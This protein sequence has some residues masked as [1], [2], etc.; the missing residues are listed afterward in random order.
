MGVFYSPHYYQVHR[1][2]RPSPVRYGPDFA[3]LSDI[4]TTRAVE[5]RW[6]G[7]LP[8][9]DVTLMVGD[10]GVGKSVLACEI[11]AKITTGISLPEETVSSPPARA[12]VITL[13]DSLAIWDA[14]FGAADGNK[15]LLVVK[16]EATSFR[17]S[18]LDTLEGKYGLIII[19]PAIS[20]CVAEQISPSNPEKVRGLFDNLKRIA[21]KLD[22]PILVIHHPNSRGNPLG[23]PAWRA[24]VRSQLILGE[25]LDGTLGLFHDKHNYSEKQLPAQFKKFTRNNGSFGLQYLGEN[26]D[27]QQYVKPRP[28]AGAD[29]GSLKIVAHAQWA[30]ETLKEY[31]G[32]IARSMLDELWAG[33]SGGLSTRTLSMVLER[34]EKKGAIERRLNGRE[35][36]LKALA[37]LDSIPDTIPDDL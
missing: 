2:P 5:S 32:L 19:D 7:R 4:P 28:K 9:G 17:V 26:Q 10:G 12:C 36:V 16:T 6:N 27:L 23:G 21:R 24:A 14:R 31:R 33:Y 34:A 30:V 18:Q 22:A 11:A 1:A 13:E 15:N 35:I 20:L 29:D 37:E 3:L 8:I 25:Q